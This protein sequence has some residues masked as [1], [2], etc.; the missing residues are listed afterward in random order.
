MV[1]YQAIVFET[2]LDIGMA[3]INWQGIARWPEADLA[4]VGLDV[5]NLLCALG[6]RGAG[7]IDIDECRRTLDQWA[8]R[9]REE[10]TRLGYLFQRQ[11]ESYLN[12]EAYFRMMVLVTVL[13]RDLG[14]H[15]SPRFT[16]MADS[17]FFARPE[18]LF[19]HGVLKSREGTCSSLPPT[20]AAVGR[21]LGYPLKLVTASQHIFLRW[22]GPTGERFN[23]ECTSQG[24]V[25][26]TDEHYRQWPRELS[27]EQLHRYCALQSL[28]PRQEL[29]IFIGNRGHVC[30]END[31]LWGAVYSYLHA[32]D[33]HCENW[34]WSNSLLDAMN[35][36]DGKLRN[37]T[38]IGFPSMAILFPSRG[39]PNVPLDLERG[40]CEMAAREKLLTSVSNQERWW[41]SLR[42]DPGNPP[43]DLPAHVTVRF[44]QKAGDTLDFLFANR[45]PD[46]YAQ[47]KT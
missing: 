28:T 15:Y 41:K 42:R 38:P 18:H 33:L 11:P 8:A 21:R 4:R 13:Q 19:I 16:A 27:D 45:R 39:F 44:P 9:V 46:G 24:L 20:F 35:R 47:P 32:S 43:S 31:D 14:V 12:S 36:W 29:A 10:T 3:T 6:L 1:Y 17:E 23:I 30:R 22:E 2:C 40:F 26:H 7:Q 5:A 25:C 37:L 34:S